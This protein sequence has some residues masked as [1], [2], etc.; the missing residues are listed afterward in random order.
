ME[1]A[2]VSKLISS[3]SPPPLLLPSDPMNRLFGK[4]K[5]ISSP[6]GLTTTLNRQR[7]VYDGGGSGPHSLFRCQG[8]SGGVWTTTVHFVSQR[9]FGQKFLR[10]RRSTVAAATEFL[11]RFFLQFLQTSSAR[12]PFPAHALFPGR[13][14][15]RP[16]LSLRKKVPFL[17][18]PLFFS[19][20][21]ECTIPIQAEVEKTVVG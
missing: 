20:N 3:P 10:R 18:P 7:V 6:P 12:K 15:V 17:L 4:D 13:N 2:F 14:R 16:K 21:R 5:K 19:V 8:G 9:H 1:A 11:S